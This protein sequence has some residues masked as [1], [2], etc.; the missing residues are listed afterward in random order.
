MDMTMAAWP[1]CALVAPGSQPGAVTSERLSRLRS[2][3]LLG[4][5]PADPG[6]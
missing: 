1:R 6:E 4:A 5:P 2:V 3:C